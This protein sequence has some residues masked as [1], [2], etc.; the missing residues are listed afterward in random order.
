MERSLGFDQ[1]HFSKG[2][3]LVRIDVR[4]ENMGGFRMPNGLERGANAHY[5]P[6]GWT[7]GGAPEAV[8][9]P[10]PAALATIAGA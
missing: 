5:K 4:P 10:V 9:D 6:G 8:I 3:G 2:R 1:D 7:S